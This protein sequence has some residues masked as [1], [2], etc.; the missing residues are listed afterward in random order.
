MGIKENRLPQVNTLG[1]RDYARIVTSLGASRRLPFTALKKGVFGTAENGS[2]GQLLRSKGNGLTEWANA[3]LPTDEQ[4]AQAVSDWLDAHPEATTTVE[5]GSLTLGKFEEGAISFVSPEQFGAVGDGVTDDTEAWQAAVDSG[6]PVRATGK[7]YKVEQIDVTKN[8]IIDANGADFT[9]SGDKCFYCKGE[10]VAT[11]TDQPDYSNG[12]ENYAITDEEYSDYTGFAMLKGT[13][14]FELSRPYYL[15]GFVCLFWDGVITSPYPIDVTGVS[16]EIINPVTVVIKNVGN[17]WHDGEGTIPFAI[18][19][20]YGVE[21]VIE[22]VNAHGPNAY[23][24]ISFSNCMSCEVKNCYV[25]QEIGTTGT[26]SYLV[27]FNN[28]SFCG[29]RGCNLYNRFWH[30]VSTGDT[31]LCYRNYT[32]DSVLYSDSAD[33]FGDH[34][35]AVGTIIKDCTT[36]PITICAMANV[37]NVTILSNKVARKPCYLYIEATSNKVNAF[38]YIKD[39]YFCPA[40][41]AVDANVGIHIHQSP[42]STGATYYITQ[43]NI[44]NAICDKK[45]GAGEFRHDGIA[46]NTLIYYDFIIDNTNLGI[47]GVATA[48]VTSGVVDISNW[49]LKLKNVSVKNVL[50]RYPTLYGNGYSYNNLDLINSKFHYV[51]G[52]IANLAINNVYIATAFSQVVTGRIEGNGVHFKIAKAV[53]DSATSVGISDMKTNDTTTVFNVGK[54]TNGTTYWQRWVNGTLTTESAS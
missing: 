24:F 23:E 14:N 46:D 27:A 3:G 50:D 38:Y 4:T 18:H 16:I 44:T 54:S 40:P 36:G 20:E 6:Y 28:S 35:N 31:Y 32:V 21:C 43:L 9:Y 13:N 51:Y 47:V 34:E 37:E 12:Q 42:R 22:S 52:A 26:N 39:V 48:F 29:V 1:T 53:F 5:D 11:L 41:D 7:A 19:V 49:T 45:S 25:W 15:G 10:V 8:T 30:A 33:S 17:L 2:Q